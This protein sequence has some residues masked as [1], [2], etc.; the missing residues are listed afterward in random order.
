MKFE[1]RLEESGLPGGVPHMSDGSE[2]KQAPDH[3][4]EIQ[5]ECA[6]GP[7]GRLVRV[8]LIE[9]NSDDAD[10][11]F[12]ALLRG[13]DPCEIERVETL[14]A[15]FERLGRGGIDVAV[16]DL[17]LPDSSGVETLA[18]IHAQFPWTPVV[19]L[20]G[21]AD[22][23]MGIQAVKEGAQDYLVKGQVDTR[24][25]VRSIRYAIERSRLDRQ[26]GDFVHV[27]THEIRNPLTVV[28]G[29]LETLADSDPGTWTAAQKGNIDRALRNAGLLSKIIDTMLEISRL[30]SG[31]ALIQ[32]GRVRAA[33]VIRPMLQ[34]FEAEARKRK[35]RL[36][37]EIQEDLPDICANEDLVLQVLMNLVQNALRFASS[38]VL[39]RAAANGA[40]AQ[41]SVIDDGEGIP[42][43]QIG[44]V[45][46]RFVQLK[47]RSRGGFYKGT[48]LG[49]ALCKQIVELHH[50]KIWVE[51]E[52][53]AG[54]AFHVVFPYA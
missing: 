45:F 48:G 26:R 12:K 30:E 36:E 39:V 3:A 9:D 24:L 10:Y 40:G 27:L 20:T 47:R 15:A 41:I 1:D 34:D 53:G 6:A 19:V 32:F 14:A 37:E 23:S 31:N 35:I 52:E 38:T 8:L 50:G 18:R 43:H 13:T 33:G 29:S 7:P 16:L 54:A 2:V 51:S 44:L 22:E 28:R 42:D 49:L 25:L 5:R 46:N 17:S 21:R 4:A 11:F